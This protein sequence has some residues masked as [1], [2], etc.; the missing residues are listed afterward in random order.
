[1]LSSIILTDFGLMM[2]ESLATHSWKVIKLLVL[3]RIVGWKLN[4]LALDTILVKRRPQGIQYMITN[5]SE[6]WFITMLRCVV[7]RMVM[8][9]SN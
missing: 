2:A 8:S 3:P 1:M 7:Y 4:F 9:Y 6:L 5:V